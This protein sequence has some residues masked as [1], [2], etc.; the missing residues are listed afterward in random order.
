MAS[1]KKGEMQNH[2]YLNRYKWATRGLRHGEKQNNKQTEQ[3]VE[4]WEIAW[5][6]TQK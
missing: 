3:E 5:I 6:R 1:R 2:T 4:K